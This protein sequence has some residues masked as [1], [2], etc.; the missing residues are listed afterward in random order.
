[1]SNMK[2]IQ[3]LTKSIKI[4]QSVGDLSSS[5]VAIEIDSRKV[6][7]GSLF[8]AINGVQSDGHLFINKAINAGAIAIV[9]ETMPEEFISGVT[10]LQ[11]N[12][13]QEAAALL[14]V[15]FYDHPSRKLKL[16]GVTGTNGKTTIATILFKLFRQLGYTC[17]LISTVQN[18]INDHIIP[19]TH[20]TPDA[21]QLNALLNTMVIEGCTHVFMESSSHAIHQHRI[22]GLNFA[23]ALFSN[24]THD[25]LDYHKTFEEY[26]RVKKSFFDQLPATAFAI[27][28]ADDKG[29]K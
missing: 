3:E 1:M 4:K 5:V 25:H 10:Y 26:I 14:A 19:A 21:I 12:N 16:V 22:T 17:G 7:V 13:S 9:C 18:Q 24:I 29:E 28:N 20:T 8:V 27:S 23:G 6:I 2:I 11:V 15:E